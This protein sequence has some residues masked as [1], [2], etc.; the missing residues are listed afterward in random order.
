[1]SF[2][3]EIMIDIFGASIARYFLLAG[4]PFLLHYYILNNYFANNKIQQRKARRKDFLRDILYSSQTTIVFTVLAFII[5]YSP[6]NQYTFVY[7]DV[8]TYP[9]WWIPVSLVLTLIVHDTYFYWLHRF[10]HHKKVYKYV[11]IVHHKSV[12]P[13]P[14]TSYSFHLLEAIL[15]GLVLIPLVLLMPLHPIT[16]ILFTVVGFI[17]NV[18]GHLGYEIAPKQLRN[19]FLFKIF[20][21]SVHHNLHHS[22]FKGNYGLYFR[23]WDNVMGTENP[24]YVEVYDKIQT[25]RFGDKHANI[26]V[27]TEKATT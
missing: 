25:Q 17:I 13:S 4:I 24:N 9:I 2:G 16:I 11:H 27:K 8:Y 1:M 23:F 12:N 22:K 5:V 18:Y 6:L 26:Q 15:E 7:F 20:N 19:S 14:W 21:T 10:M 3:Y